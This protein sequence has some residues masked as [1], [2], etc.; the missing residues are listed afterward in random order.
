M[1]GYSGPL[2]G[3]CNGVFDG[4]HATPKESTE[5]PIFLG[6]TNVTSDGK[7]D[8]SDIRHV[9]EQEFPRWT[10]RVTPQPGDIVFS[11]EATLHRYALIPEGFR[12]C[13]GRRMGL[14]RVDS[15]KVNAGFLHYYFLSREWR[16][17][18]ESSVI[19]G[20]TV[21]RIPLTRFPDFPI[22]IPALKEQTR[23]A[24]I[25]SAYDDLS[26]NNRRRIKLLEDAA[27][28]LYREWFVHFRFP[29]HEHVKIVDGVPKGWKRLAVDDICTVARGASPRPISLF[30]GGTVP[31]LK[32]GDA[33]ASESPFIFMSVTAIA[34]PTASAAVVLAVGARFK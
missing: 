25:L 3:V 19:T 16:A 31:W 18:V 8:F 33:T 10:R 26:E 27:R 30:M 2:R 34:S 7:L 12:G 14:V 29:G 17:V 9:S 22:H 1:T 15:G 28:L 13:L 11:Y 23:I 6:I 4:P 20:A 5:G 21:D 32:I 24:E